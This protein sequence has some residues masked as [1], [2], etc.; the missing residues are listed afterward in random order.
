[1][2]T[3]VQDTLSAS[4]VDTFEAHIHYTSTRISSVRLM[5]RA[6]G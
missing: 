6:D 3:G 1:M 5:H 2:A 4:S